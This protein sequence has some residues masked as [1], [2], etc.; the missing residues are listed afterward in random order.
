MVEGDQVA[1]QRSGCGSSASR[2]RKAVTLTG[3]FWLKPCDPGWF[4]TDRMEG[5]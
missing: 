3:V 1:L 2:E 4:R 5:I